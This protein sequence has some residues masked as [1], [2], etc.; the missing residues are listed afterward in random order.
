MW[1]LQKLMLL[2][3]AWVFPAMVV[4]AQQ[5]FVSPAANMAAAAANPSP[6]GPEQASILSLREFFAAGGAIGHVIVFFSILMTAI[7]IDAA[8]GLR[9]NLFMPPGLAE[10]VHRCLAEHK[11]QELRTVC[12]AHPSFLSTVLLAGAEELSSAQWAPVEKAMEDTAAE[13]TARISRRVEYLSVISTL[14]P[15]LGLMGTVWGMILAF[16]EF[17]QKANPQI[18]ELA[19]GIYKALVTTLQGLAV[20]ILSIGALAF[21]RR[22]IDDLAME[23]TLLAGRIFADQRRALQKR[24]AEP[25]PRAH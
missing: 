24:R 13:Q 1:N 5:E 10:E 12:R 25:T 16:M 20:A 8:V 7:I 4:V 15:M 22:R 11:G 19:P 6:A 23:S 14:A 3:A 17:E 21:F 9:R 2:A 18:S